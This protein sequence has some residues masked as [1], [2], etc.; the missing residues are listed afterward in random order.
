MSCRA[1]LMQAIDCVYSIRFQQFSNLCKAL[2]VTCE[3]DIKDSLV[4]AKVEK[5]E[6]TSMP[7]HINVIGLYI[8]PTGPELIRSNKQTVHP[9]QRSVKLLRDIIRLYAPNPTNIVVDLCAETM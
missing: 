9:E 4:K 3:K 2:A 8:P 7:A 1:S 5:R 6:K